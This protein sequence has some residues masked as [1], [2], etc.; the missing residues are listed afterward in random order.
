LTLLVITLF[1][2]KWSAMIP[3]ATLAATLAVVSYH[4]SEWRTFRSEL[5]SPK[6]D[7]AVLLTTFLLTVLVDL[8]VAVSVGVV[9]AS[10][11]FIRRMSE[12]TGVTELTGVL[13]DSDEDGAS[14]S[15]GDSEGVRGRVPEGVEVYEI[16]GPFFFGAAATFKDTLARVSRKPKVLIISMA[17]VPTL[18]S[19]AMHAL[20]DVIHRSRE[21]GTAVVLAC[22]Q[23]QP[24]RALNASQILVE[25][26]TGEPFASLE[27][28]IEYSRTVPGVEKLS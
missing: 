13:D 3:M 18:D 11:L 8:T 28:A 25:V 4:M 20:K 6:S 7:V 2:A 1:A 21:D 10:F 5:H 16:N 14:D 24:L 27:S 17:E 22:V 23:P 26:A 19:T 15:D 12:V 9:L